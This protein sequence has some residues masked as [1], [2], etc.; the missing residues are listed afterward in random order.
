MRNLSS[1]LRDVAAL[2]VLVTCSGGAAFAGPLAPP[3]GPVA[4]SGKTLTEVEPRISINAA[5][6][7][8]DADSMYRIV[9]PGSYYLTGNLFA[10]PDRTCIEIAA[11]NVT[12][13]LMG[14]RILGSP[15]GSIHGI[16]EDSAS[17]HAN[18]RITNG[19]ITGCG[20]HGIFLSNDSDSHTIDHIQSYNNG[21]FGRPSD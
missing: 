10:N 1:H 11:S 8:G 14:F 6:T 18:I 21:E 5:H 12:I 2:L 17:L 16:A 15:L 13:D 4:S 3:I 20:G 19:S 9:A 7:P